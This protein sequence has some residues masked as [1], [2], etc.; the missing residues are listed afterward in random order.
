MFRASVPVELE[1]ADTRPRFVPILLRRSGP[2]QG[3]SFLLLKHITAIATDCCHDPQASSQYEQ[4]SRKERAQIIALL[5][6]GSSIR[7]INR[8]TGFAQ[9][10]IMKLLVDLGDAATEYQNQ[11]L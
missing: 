9:N 7:S 8:L 2:P 1:A 4:L 5:V 3:G 10:T 6:E 11:T